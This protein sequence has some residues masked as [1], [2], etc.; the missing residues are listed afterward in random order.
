[1]LLQAMSAFLVEKDVLLIMV[2]VRDEKE[3]SARG[4]ATWPLGS[5]TKLLHRMNSILCKAALQ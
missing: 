4:M 2:V 3:F 1:M 5:L